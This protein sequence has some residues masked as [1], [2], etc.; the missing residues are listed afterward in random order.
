MVKPPLLKKGDRIAIVA[1]A[2]KIS[3][4]EVDSSIKVL[5]E[6]GFQVVLSRH[7]DD[8]T[9]SYL[10]A[11]DD[12]RLADLQHYLDDA[13]ISAVICARGGYGSTRIIDR[14]DLRGLA[15]S[16]KWLVGFS[17][18]TAI[19]LKLFK[20]RVMSIH[21]TMP[22]LFSKRDSAVSVD[23]LLTVLSSGTFSLRASAHGANRFGKSQGP[24][25]GGNLSL[26]ADSLGTQSELDTEN[27]I[28]V[29]EEIDEYFYRLDRMMTQLKRAGK[30][31]NLSGIVIGH[32]TDMKESELPF[33]ESVVQIILDKVKEYQYPVAFGF[34]TGHENP[35]LAWIHGHMATLTVT[36]SGSELSADAIA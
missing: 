29:L 19:H 10:A 36:E 1:P 7:L 28:L 9:H 14:L 35:N 6:H 26:I 33:G 8:N 30:L 11:G 16:P 22:V 34:P 3:P 20:Q 25:V 13:S 27:C 5:G 17:D 4:A 2:R 21:G 18:I 31:Q 24:L 32:I 23:S 15:T 12:Q